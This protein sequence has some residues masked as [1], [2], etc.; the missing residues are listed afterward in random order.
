MRNNLILLTTI[1]LALAGVSH[2]ATHKGEVEL[3]FLGGIALESSSEGSTQDDIQAGQI[4]ADFDSWFVSGGISWFRT[5][6]LQL[7][8]AGFGNWMSGS[9]K[10]CITPDP[11][12]FPEVVDVYDYD[13]DVTVY[14]VGGRAKWC[15]GTDKPLVPF[16]GIQGS[17]A[18]ADIDV[19]GQAYQEISG[20]VDDTSLV[21]V[22]ES[23]SASGIMW[24]P[25]LGI[26][27]EVGEKDE[28]LVEYQYQMWTGDLGDILDSGHAIAIGLAHR[29]N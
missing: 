10:V 22:S 14:G 13:V 7:G 27:L 6:N 17:W 20:V 21:D 8:I 29:L 16:I 1:V 25:I 24:G 18:T 28:I 4:G 3:E 19:S 12:D 11:L 23:D 2:A 26:R 15:F 5:D 9:E